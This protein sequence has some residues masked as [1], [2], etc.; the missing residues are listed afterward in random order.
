MPVVGYMAFIFAL[1]SISKTPA[2]PGGAD[3][4][5][6]AVLYAG[7]GSLVVRAFSGGWDELV[8]IRTVLVTVLVCCA[9]GISDEFHQWFVPPRSVEAYDVVADTVGGAIAALGLYVWSRRR[10]V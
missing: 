4:D 9:Y 1:S 2:L 10:T 6:H 7:L 3:K 5:L 8:S